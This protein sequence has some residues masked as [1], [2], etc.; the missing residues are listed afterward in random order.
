MAGR[1]IRNSLQLLKRRAAGRTILPQA[2]S[3]KLGYEG[4]RKNQ[5]NL[6]PPPSFYFFLTLMRNQPT[7]TAS[8]YVVDLGIQPESGDARYIRQV[9]DRG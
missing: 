5:C 8:A 7:L 1:R 4:F 2:L 6:S 9:R 3:S